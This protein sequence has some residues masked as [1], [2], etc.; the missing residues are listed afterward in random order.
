MNKQNSL[1]LLSKVA[2]VLSGQLIGDDVSFTSVSIDSRSLFNGALFVALKGPNFNGH[3]YLLAA[4][5]AGAVAALVEDFIDVDIAQIKVADTYVALTQMAAWY[6]QQFAVKTV[7]ITGSCGKTTTR[8]LLEN[9]LSQTASVL[10]TQGNYNNHLGVPLMLMQLREHHQFMVLELGADSVGEIAH[11]TQ[12]VQPSVGA[13]TLAAPAHIETF[14][15]IQGV[16]QGKGE[17]FAGLSDTGVAIMNR[18]DQFYDY[19]SG[20]AKQRRK[21]TFGFHNDADVR[22]CD[23][24]VQDNGQVAFQLCYMSSVP[25]WVK[26]PLLGEYNVMNALAAAAAA[27]ALGVDVKSVVSGLQTASA[28]AARMVRRPGLNGATVV[29]DTYNAN[30]CSVKAAIETLASFSGKRIFVLGDML[31][32]GDRAALWHSEVGAQVMD[33]GVDHFFG[34]GDLAGEAIRAFGAEG[35]HFTT[36]EALIL[37]LKKELDSST[38]VMVKGSNS[39]NMNQIVAAV[40]ASTD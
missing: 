4:K 10:A 3:N 12:L 25:Q 31:E 6:R 8:A 1:L 9:I 40:T 18:D 14:G 37:A 5:Q 16:A 35:R 11:L 7:A 33:N 27:M 26:L 29:D 23:V 34:F 24:V 39:L 15:S 13:V 28:V 22:A 17:L 36:Q 20:L 32:L 2:S 30:P 21:V 38:I 19:W